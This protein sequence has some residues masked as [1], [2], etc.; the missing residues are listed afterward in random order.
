MWLYNL[1]RWLLPAGRLVFAL[2]KRGEDLPARDQPVLI[3]AN[4][5]SFLDPWVVGS[6]DPQREIHFLINERWYRRSRLWTALFDAWGVLPAS[7]RSPWET[8]ERVVAALGRGQSVGIFPE[9]RISEDGKI[10]RGRPGI[11]WMAA[12]SGCP[13]VPCGLRGIFE[14]LPKGRLLPRRHRVSI[15]VGRPLYF[16]AK[17]VRDPE[18]GQLHDFAGK[19][20]TTICTLA[21]QEDRVA[22]AL[23][24]DAQADAPGPRKI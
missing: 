18:R 22:A 10:G 15:H 3:A 13:V 12:L 5:S 6:V 24:L 16:S 2:E 14:A 23:P 4:H 17:A 8:I 21:G 7:S 9:G 11:A 19:V 1:N 20:M